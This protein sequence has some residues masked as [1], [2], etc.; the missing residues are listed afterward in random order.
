MREAPAI[1]MIPRH[2]PV[3]HIYREALTV[4]EN[5][6]INRMVLV[7]PVEELLIFVLDLIVFMLV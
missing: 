2:L 1:L 4:E 5:L 7:A 6:S 3:A